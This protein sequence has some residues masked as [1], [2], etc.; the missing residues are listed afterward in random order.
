MDWNKTHIYE[1]G[2]A[3]NSVWNKHKYLHNYGVTLAS[4]V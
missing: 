2:Y 3:D 1:W 4:Y